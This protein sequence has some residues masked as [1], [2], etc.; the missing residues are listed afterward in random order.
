MSENGFPQQGPSTE[1][2]PPAAPGKRRKWWIIG[3]VAALVFVIAGLSGAFE[4]DQAPTA[5]AGTPSTSGSS[6]A[7]TTASSETDKST[8]SSESTEG[9]SSTTTSTTTESTPTESTTTAPLPGICGEYDGLGAA[10]VGLRAAGLDDAALTAA[11]DLATESCPELI[12]PLLLVRSERETAAAEAEAAAQEPAF[13]PETFEGSGDDVLSPAIGSTFALVTF[14]CPNCSSN[15]VVKTDGDES[16]LVN[17]IG[18]YSGNHLINVMDGSLTS[19]IE[20]NADA[21]WTLT[22]TDPK[23]APQVLAGRGD[24]VIIVPAGTTKA[25]LSHNGTSNFAIWV[26]NEDGRDLAVNEIGAYEGTVVL[27]TPAFVQITAD[28]D[29]TISP[30]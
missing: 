17:A 21:P 6:E 16:L 8:E 25:A 23:D 22:I 24:Q 9:T 19:L 20:V 3:G 26:L 27:R 15:T 4:R 7:A 2:Q 13:V 30:S 28:G 29:W 14:S 1:P 12:F 5:L 18:S 10:E 11:V